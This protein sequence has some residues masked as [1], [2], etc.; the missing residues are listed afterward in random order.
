MQILLDETALILESAQR[1]PPEVNLGPQGKWAKQGESS[2]DPSYKVSSGMGSLSRK[3]PTGF[4]AH[5]LQM[6][7]GW[8][9]SAIVL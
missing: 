6:A 7:L 5:F 1:I 4:P 9:T 3:S 8:M 2:V